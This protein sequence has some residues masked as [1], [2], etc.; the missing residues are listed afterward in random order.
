MATGTP[1]MSVTF[2]PTPVPAGFT[3]V[4]Q[5]TQGLSAG[6]NNPGTKFRQITTVAAAGTSPANTLTA[7]TTKFG[8]VPAIGLK[9]FIRAFFVNNTTGQTGQ[10]LQ[11]SVT[12]T[13]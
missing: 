13:A 10:P 1:A 2:T 8:S 11:A 7:Y 3:L 12:I 6:I 9:V 4:I 5:A